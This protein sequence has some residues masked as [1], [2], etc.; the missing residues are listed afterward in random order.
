ME[1]KKIREP[2]TDM[3]KVSPLDCDTIV[4][5]VREDYDIAGLAKN[6]LENGVIVSVRAWRREDGKWIIIEGHRRLAA[7]MMLINGG[8]AT[9]GVEEGQLFLRVVPCRKP[10]MADWLIEQ[11]STSEGG[12]RLTVLEQARAYS[13]LHNEHNY[14]A[15]QIAEMLGGSARHIRDIIRLDSLPDAMKQLIASKRIGTTHLLRM[16]AEAPFEEVQAAIEEILASE[17]AQ[18]GSRTKISRIKLEGQLA[19]K[20]QNNRPLNSVGILKRVLKQKIASAEAEEFSLEMIK[21]EKREAFDLAF[22]I[23]SGKVSED[24]IN[25]YFI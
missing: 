4:G 23:A 14:S 19:T 2:R 13:R 8:F 17:A 24:E 10:K 3:Y 20:G 15:E 7:C 12:K 22:R 21:P 1:K 6:I 11:L 9:A 5:N 25:Q 18:D 16:L